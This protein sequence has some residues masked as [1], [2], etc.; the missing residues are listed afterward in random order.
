MTDP[1][2]GQARKRNRRG[3]TPDAPARG[4]PLRNWLL[5]T[6]GMM[7]AAPIIGIFAGFLLLFGGIFLGVAWQMAV[8]P[9]VDAHR[10]APF[11]ATASGKIVESWAALDFDPSS[12]PAGKLYWDRASKITRCA[13]VEYSAG[14]WG[15]P[16]RRAFCGMQ[17]KFGED[18]RL[19]DWTEMLQEGI[20]FTFLRD[21][22]GFEIQEIRLSK[23]ALEWISTHPPRDTFMMS[24]PPPT[25]ALAALNEQLDWP[26]DIAVLSWTTTVPA[27]PLRYDPKDPASAMPAKTV[28]DSHQWNWLGAILVV[29]LA[30]PGLFVWR[31]GMQLFFATEPS[32]LVI[33]LLT[34]LPLL[35]LPWWG[36]ALP[37][38]LTHV[39]RNWAAIASDMLDDVSRSTRILA[40]APEDAPFARGERLTWRLDQGEYAQTFGRIHFSK[41]DP[42][43]KTKE[44]V[45]ATLRAQASAQVARFTPREQLALL[46]HLAQDKENSR[47]R[48][49]AIFTTAAEAIERD[50]NADTPVH[51]AARHFLLLGAGYNVWDVDALEKSWAPAAKP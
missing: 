24:K 42:A 12:L 43:P 11:T 27:F 39:N 10:Y 20:P 51:R 50:A 34:L 18:F 26:I 36:D 31:L 1:N 30:I 21:A 8:Q 40:S 49:Q 16:L 46:E 48:D 37:K 14:E 33:W 29:L 17:L 47:D 25:T 2:P 35:A 38:L 5:G 45:L 44:E 13:V 15:A 32:P 4:H 28:A 22:S 7:A 23:A 9:I 6:F 3:A 41:P 19:H